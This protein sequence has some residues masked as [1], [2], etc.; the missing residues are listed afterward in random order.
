[1]KNALYIFR[2]DI[3]RILKNKV[4][5]IVIG[6]VCI[7]PSLYAWFNI[8]A[9]MDPYANTDK[10]KVAIV[11]NDTEVTESGISVN[12]GKEIVDNLKENK[13]LDWQF[14]EEE[15]GI[16]G[17]KSGK[18]YAAIV[19]QE[20]FSKSLLS[21]TSGDTNE[22]SLIYYVN[23]KKNAIA[24]KITST[25]A[26]TIQEQINENF[27]SV[28]AKSVSDIVKESA[29]SIYDDV[30]TTK[31]N[32]N[33]SLKN[34]S[35]DF[36]SY[37]KNIQD[38]QQSANSTKQEIDGILASID[39]ITTFINSGNQALD[40][41]DNII[42][43]TN[44]A[45]GQL[46]TDIFNTSTENMNYL[47]DIYTT[48]SASINRQIDKTM[49]VNNKIKT[50][51]DLLSNVLANNK[52]IL[53]ELQKENEQNNGKF[54]TAIKNLQDKN[55]EITNTINTLSEKQQLFTQ[56]IEKLE[57][58]DKNLGKLIDDCNNRLAE[59]G[60]VISEN[61]TNGI[62]PN[63]NKLLSLIGKMQGTLN[64]APETLNL[65]KSVLKETQNALDDAIIAFSNAEN[66]VNSIKTNL[67]DMTQDLSVLESSKVF[68]NLVS[69]ENI[70]A[71]SIGNFI[72]S[73]VEVQ[74]TALYPVK[75]YGS[76]MTPFYT[77]LA[78]W[79]G[80]IVLV[81]VIKLEVDTDEEL[82]GVKPS[83]SYMGRLMLLIVLA[84][85]QGFIATA[86]DIW[87]LG[88]QCEIPSLFIL[89]GIICSIVFTNIIFALAITFKHIG[90][91]LCVLFIILQIPGG[92]GT[93]PI[94]MTPAFF[95]TI[96]PLLP[97]S[98]GISAMREAIAGLYAGT[99]T[100]DVMKLAIFIPISLVIGLHL[101]PLL[102]NINNLFDK[103][104]SESGLMISEN[105]TLIRKTN[106][107]DLLIKAL[108]N[109]QEITTEFRKRKEN[110][111]R[112]YKTK[113]KR[114]LFLLCA[115][116]LIF[117]NLMLF[118]PAKLTCLILW[119]I[120]MIL[121]A[122]YLIVIEYINNKLT[123]E[124]ELQDMTSDEI[125]EQLREED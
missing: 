38:L 56:V 124:S 59:L 19:I 90:K 32:L 82:I 21:I 114:G 2:R 29:L 113:I 3:K 36:E 117:L 91:A 123:V 62:S 99:Y 45:S 47:N 72:E 68:K 107:A 63:A 104:L 100:Y 96:H 15:V 14:V 34:V 48:T 40:S 83:E 1:M 58:S 43:K 67:D 61:V 44:E 7:I 55:Q 8:A 111:E 122:T 118:I 4:A 73:P 108:K 70:D 103:K 64:A 5:L 97:F 112:T 50:Q 13:K 87:L 37:S 39:K 41:A 101:R 69:L 52:A 71:D 10:I 65:S 102:I 57:T 54:D 46:S 106:H 49:T 22:P 18:Y 28:A 17:V 75:N 94:E 84:A 27:S 53:E 33:T 89:S 12:A 110:F 78:L 76:A 35:E 26:T 16:D 30:E 80:G 120:S 81:S 115:L 11:N 93:Y 86:G 119:I 60:K 42:K 92:A 6:G 23:E 9:N 74:T 121:T 24:P 85:F 31:D 51:I 66:L 79:V 88:A 95:R 98:Y 116:P 20:D 125:I 105:N 77:N 109:D 25:G